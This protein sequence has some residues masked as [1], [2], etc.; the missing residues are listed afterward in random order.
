MK[1]L[2]SIVELLVDLEEM[3]ATVN[4]SDDWREIPAM[5]RIYMLGDVI[6]QLTSELDSTVIEWKRGIDDSRRLDM[7]M[8]DQ[9]SDEE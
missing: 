2:D 1:K 4:I 6:A 5:F 7:W 3:Q 8:R 9:V